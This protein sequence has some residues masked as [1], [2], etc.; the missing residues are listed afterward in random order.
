MQGLVTVWQA[1]PAGK[2]V[3]LVGAVLATVFVFSI[4]ARTASSPSMALL[5]SGLEPSASGDVI[6]A[7]ERMNI[8]TD[9]RGDT[10]YVPSNQRDFVRMSL[11]REG[12]PQQGQAGYELF[13]SL[14]GFSTTSDIFDVTYW[15]ALEGE[16]ARTILAAP[17]VRAARVHI[18]NE[19]NVSFSRRGAKPKAVV[20]VTMG[21]GALT[22]GQANSIRYLVS[23]SVPGLA[24][25]QVAVLDSARGVILSPGEADEMMDGLAGAMDREKQIEADILNII[26][27]RVGSGNARVQVMLE[28]DREREAISERVFDPE[29]RVMSGKE[30]TEITESSSGANSGSITVASN[31]PEGDKNG[32]GAKSNSERTQTDESVKYDLSEIRRERQKAPGAT[33]RLSVAVL[34]NN[35]ET[36]AADGAVEFTPR[37]DEELVQLRELVAMAVGFNEERGDTLTI[38]NM[39]FK[40]IA[41]DDGTTVEESFVASFMERHL[42]TSIQIGVLSIVTL[43]LGLFVVKPVLSVK[44]LPAPQ[45]DDFALMPTG[46]AQPAEL[47]AADPPDAMTALRGLA[48]DKTDE[49]ATLI[50][51]WLEE[52]AA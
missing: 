7:L 28:I 22:K 34:V 46:G 16:L 9:V 5:Y 44:S 8:E 6:M 27:A 32:G 39:A 19:R 2:R 49:T 23:S 25:E 11:A 30:T 43:I 3:T 4:L 51:A 40:P 1:L 31:L 38:Q 20:T 13:E 29:G 33:K 15:R 50:K 37:S 36:T 12:L 10:I 21:R 52:D 45:A 18:A 47:T 24:A 48:S 26:E 17:G 14:S 41:N 35:I 42:M